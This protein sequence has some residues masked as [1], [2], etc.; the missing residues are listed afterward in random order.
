MKSNLQLKTLQNIYSKNISKYKIH[1]KS[2]RQNT[3]AKYCFL[4]FKCMFYN[5]LK[6]KLYASLENLDK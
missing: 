3:I 5:I 6:G 1:T 2:W 4:Y